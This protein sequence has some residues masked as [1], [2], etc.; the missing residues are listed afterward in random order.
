[1]MGTSLATS[2]TVAVVAH[3]TSNIKSSNSSNINCNSNTHHPG[4]KWGKSSAQANRASS[5]F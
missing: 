4:S 5:R 3:Y 2:A 1:M